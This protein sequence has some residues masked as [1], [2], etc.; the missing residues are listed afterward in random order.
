MRFQWHGRHP[1][2][3]CKLIQ[4]YQQPGQLIR[5]SV[6]SRGSLSQ[7]G[8]CTRCLLFSSPTEVYV[9]LLLSA[10][11]SENNTGPQR[12][13]LNITVRVSILVQVLFSLVPASHFWGAGTSCF[14]HFLIDKLLK[15]LMAVTHSSWWL[16]KTLSARLP[17]FTSKIVLLL[18]VKTQ[19]NLN[20]QTRYMTHT[21]HRAQVQWSRFCLNG[22]T[23][24]LRLL[25]HLIRETN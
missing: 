2:L 22:D 14:W 24:C 16:F 9:N 3:F 20:T 19:S 17:Q 4:G 12:K 18:R 21:Q 10:F 7:Q 6:C 15:Q 8:H 23:Q 5:Q 13:C 11:I 25:K 1:H